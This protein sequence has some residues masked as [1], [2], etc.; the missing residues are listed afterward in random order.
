M[1]TA[2]LPS[3]LSAL[4]P[5]KETDRQ[6]GGCPPPP[7]P[8]PWA[9]QGAAGD[10]SPSELSSVSF[11]LRWGLGVNQLLGAVSPGQLLSSA[12]AWG[13]DGRGP[14]WDIG[15]ESPQ[16]PS[17][18]DLLGAPLQLEVQECFASIIHQERVTRSP[19]CPLFSLQPWSAPKFPHL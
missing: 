5:R 1:A 17:L 12:Q 10:S 4:G 8:P 18:S 7:Q 15:R 11:L 16:P 2:T 3:P 9:P 6:A 14:G 19:S 13:G